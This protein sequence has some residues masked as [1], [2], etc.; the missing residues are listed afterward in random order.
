MSWVSNILVSVD[1]KDRPTVE[2]LN[3]WLRTEAPRRDPGPARGVGF[4][5]DL[6][7]DP[8]NAWG[9]P[10]QPECDV[11]GGALNHADLDAVV[12]KFAMLPWRTPA[13]AQLLVMDQEQSYFRLWMLRNGA[14]QQY[15][16][17]PP[18][19]DSAW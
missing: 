4:L 5:N 7:S 14:P 13:A 18:D 3:T 9:G 15:A 2:M 12:A 19:G 10:K 17:E 11:W 1:R 8:D 16:P 6:T